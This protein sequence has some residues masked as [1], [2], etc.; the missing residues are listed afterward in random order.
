MDQYIVVLPP[1]FFSIMSKYLFNPQRYDQEAA[2]VRL[3]PRAGAGNGW[4]PA[5][6]RLGP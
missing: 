2:K 1:L 3:S 4:V 5:S 6:F